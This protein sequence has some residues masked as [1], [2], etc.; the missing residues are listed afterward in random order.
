MFAY[1]TSLRGLTQLTGFDVSGAFFFDAAQQ[2]LD[3]FEVPCSS[4]WR[5]VD[6]DYQRRRLPG[7]ALSLV[8]PACPE[9]VKTF[10]RVSALNV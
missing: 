7:H 1:R 3:R 8:A 9:I 2:V 10:N 4:F 6:L 5:D